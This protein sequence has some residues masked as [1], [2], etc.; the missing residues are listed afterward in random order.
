MP[1]VSA[2]RATLLK[3]K[4]IDKPLALTGLS[5]LN[6]DYTACM[7]YLSTKLTAKAHVRYFSKNCLSRN[8]YSQ[9]NLLKEWRYQARGRSKFGERHRPAMTRRPAVTD[10]LR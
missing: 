8:F 6:S 2:A 4:L 9:E 7:Q 10:C 5:V 3:S 1:N